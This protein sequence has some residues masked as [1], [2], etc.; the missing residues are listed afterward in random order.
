MGANKPE[1][2]NSAVYAIQKEAGRCTSYPYLKPEKVLNT[3]LEETLQNNPSPFV[4]SLDGN[5]MFNWV[6]NP[7]ER[8]IDFYKPDYDVSN[9]DSLPVPSHWELEGYGVPIYAPFHMPPSLGKKNIPNIDPQNNPVGSYRLNFNIP[10]SWQDREILI[11]FEGVASAFYLWINGQKVGYSQDSMLP[12]EFNITAYLHEGIN[13]LAVEN[14]RWCDGSYLENQDMWFLSGIFRSVKLIAIPKMHLRDFFVNSD[15]DD[16][17]QHAEL[18]IQ[19][20]LSNLTFST[21]SG[22][23]EV[24]LLNQEQETIAAASIG[25]EVQAGQEEIVKINL[26]V[27]E[28]EKWTAETPNLYDVL[29]TLK[30]NE[31]QFLDIRNCRHGFR[32]IEIKEKQL[33]INGKQL[34]FLGVNRHDLDPIKGH[35][36]TYERMLE[37]I[38]I[39]KRN[40]INAV[41]T[42]HYPDDERFYDLCDKYGLY[43]MD[44]ANVESHGLRDQME[45]DLQWGNAIVDRVVRMFARDKNHPSIVMWSLG[46]EARAGE[47]FQKAAKALRDLD[48]SRPIHYEQDHKGEIADVYSV[49]YPTPTDLEMMANGK[50]YRSRTGPVS[51]ERMGGK[52]S[53]HLPLILCEYAHAMGNSLGSFEDFITLFEK[54]PNI[55]GG[56]IW[57]FADQSLLSQTRDGKP[58]WAMGGDLGDP[59]NYGMFCCNGILASDRSPHPALAAVKKGYQTIELSDIDM[60]NGR[61]SLKNKS[62]IKSLE[63]ILLRW[64]ILADG[65]LFQQ[66]EVVCPQV[67]PEDTEE[68]LISYT[69]PEPTPGIE[70]HLQVDFLLNENLAWAEKGHILACE[71][72][73]LPVDIPIPSNTIANTHES[74]G[75][76]IIQDAQ[77]TVKII[78]TDFKVEFNQISGELTH[79][80]SQGKTLICGP[81]R[82]NLW[83]ASIDNEVSNVYLYPWARYFGYGKTRWRQETKKRKLIHFEVI[84][85]K[86]NEIQ[87]QSR[88]RIKNGKTPFECLY[89]INNSGEIRVTCTF[90]PA[91]DLWRF[92]MQ[93]SIPTEFNVM[94]WFGLG[95]HET[96]WD[97]KLGAQVGVFIARTEEL[98]HHYVRPQENG[99]RSDIR[100]ASLTDEYDKGLLV[101]DVSGDL[102]NISVWPYT[103]EDLQKAL[104]IHELPQRD[105]LTLN[106]DHLQRGV[107]GDEPGGSDP[108]PEYRLKKNTKYTYSFN[109]KDIQR[110]TS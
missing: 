87:V 85:I 109:I 96:M 93:L 16:D 13:T 69:L 43:V 65:E 44:E 89:T 23:L 103:Q 97:R 49:M 83:R 78:G 19:S 95:P 70:F 36:M 106:I 84:R 60:K 34:L 27:H 45:K 35:T 11:H 24:K 40:N 29:L 63:N 71:Q 59:Y 37:D 98:I 105:F 52:Y 101:S 15:L 4:K 14:Y 108:H 1:W 110:K 80:S 74:P 9:W 41:R 28:P 102:L 75:E 91:K 81:M 7:S 33:L 58:F 5:W 8:P 22:T 32:K 79:F 104:H 64:T 31:D 88:W 6:S 77:D 39:M 21:Q 68:I 53:T 90:T 107:G 99:N 51:W 3:P 56:F 50:E 72:F 18:Q 62:P 73:T 66:K 46:N 57:D 86:E 26:P 55:A 61:F 2:E 67:L 100:W 82:P 25:F 76:L 92:G 48:T 42:S 54:Y 12:A 10:E 20:F 17:Y 47:N 30:N 94:T 38:L